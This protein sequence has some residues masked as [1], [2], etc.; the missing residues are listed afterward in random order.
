MAAQFHTLTVQKV[1]PETNDALSVYLDVPNALRNEYS[2]EPG[3][4]LTFKFDIN[5]EEV[6]RAY[7]MCSSPVE[8]EIAVCVKRIDKGLV[9]NYIHDSVKAGT[10]VEVMQPEGRFNTKIDPDQKKSYYLFGAGSGI[11][12]L[13]SILRTVI[14]QE[15]MSQ[16]YL[17]YGNRNEDSIIFQQK[18]DALQ[19]Q[20]SGQLKVD[21]VLSQ[22]KR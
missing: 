16:V 19:Q 11:T 6:R 14:E 8:G 20:Y 9:S 18:L 7:S 12:P 13:L 5:G 22:P 17:L 4:Y 10:P 21:Y 1:V 2:Y 3:Q 15:P